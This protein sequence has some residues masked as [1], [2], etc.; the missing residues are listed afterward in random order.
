MSIQDIPKLNKIPEKGVIL[1]KKHCEK[2]D[3][4]KQT[5]PQKFASEDFIF[6]NIHRGDKIF[7]STACGEPQY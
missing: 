5:Y 6:S 3:K 7:I 1:K 4:M 2:L